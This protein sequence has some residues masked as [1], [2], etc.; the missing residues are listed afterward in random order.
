MALVQSKKVLFE[1]T[2]KLS[3]SIG[4]RFVNNIAFITDKHIAFHFKNDN[5]NCILVWTSLQKECFHTDNGL[6]NKMNHF[7]EKTINQNNFF[8]EG[9]GL[10]SETSF[11]NSGFKELSKNANVWETINKL[12]LIGEI[13][14]INVLKYLDNIYTVD[15]AIASTTLSTDHLFNTLKTQFVNLT[16][17]EFQRKFQTIGIP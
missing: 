16:M 1:K 7:Y 4:F 9:L 13:V 12:C 11:I 8:Y 3:S 17:N 5:L 15:D 10:M 6:S 2:S 14:K